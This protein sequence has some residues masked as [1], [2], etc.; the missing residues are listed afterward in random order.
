MSYSELKAWV[1]QAVSEVGPAPIARIAEHIWK[2]HEADLRA[3]GDLFYTWQYAMRWAG[4]ELQR[5]GK[6]IKLGGAKGWSPVTV[7]S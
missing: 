7:K 1:D 4:Q 2:N 3:S 5:E 6:L